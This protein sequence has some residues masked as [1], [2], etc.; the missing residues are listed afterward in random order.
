MS[1]TKT[2]KACLAAS[3]AASALS[4]NSSTDSAALALSQSLSQAGDISEAWASGI[5]T[6]IT[7]NAQ[8]S[9]SLELELQGLENRLAL[10]EVD[11]SALMLA[12][13]QSLQDKLDQI[14]TRTNTLEA[15]VNGDQV[16]A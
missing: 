4:A 12:S 13:L 2:M 16:L 3:L 10:A 9:A 14:E 11:T 7:Q 5:D 15:K 6:K 1:T 8:A